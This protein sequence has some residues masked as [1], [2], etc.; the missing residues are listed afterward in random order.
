MKLVNLNRAIFL[1]DK[2]NAISIAINDTEKAID[3]VKKEKAKGANPYRGNLS[4]FNDGSGFKIK[5]ENTDVLESV[6]AFTFKALLEKKIE[7]ETE[8]EAL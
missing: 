8:I 4:E 7:V 3:S 2:L 1:R 6:L 5:L